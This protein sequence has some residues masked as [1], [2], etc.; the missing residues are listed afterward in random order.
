MFSEKLEH[1]Q[2]MHLMYTYQYFLVF[3]AAI[4]ESDIIS[5]DVC[6]MSIYSATKEQRYVSSGGSNV[7]AAV[8][9]GL[10]L[11]IVFVVGMVVLQVFLDSRR[12]SHDVSKDTSQEKK[13]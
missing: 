6:N 8:I 3:A 10:V 7:L 12:A 5:P 2:C 11:G 4:N 1:A 13:Q 9:V